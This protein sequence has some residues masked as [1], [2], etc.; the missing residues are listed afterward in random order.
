MGR[1]AATSR[2]ATAE[3]DDA[4]NLDVVEESTTFRTVKTLNKMR[5]K[6]FRCHSITRDAAPDVN[7]FTLVADDVAT[8]NGEVC[9]QLDGKDEVL[10]AS[11]QHF[12]GSGNTRQGKRVR[13]VIVCLM[14]QV[15]G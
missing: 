4:L 2:I 15:C 5:L 3:R 7:P 12:F 9:G 14:G 8:L 1:R 13:P 10:T 6:Q 11:A